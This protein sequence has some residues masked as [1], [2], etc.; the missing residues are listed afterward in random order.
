MW[1]SGET[2]SIV[3][4][5][6][7]FGE[8]ISKKRIVVVQHSLPPWRGPVPGGFLFAVPVVVLGL[9]RLV[10]GLQFRCRPPVESAQT[11]VGV[12]LFNHVCHA[13][14]QPWWRSDTDRD[15]HRARWY[16]R[17]VGQSKLTVPLQCGL[18]GFFGDIHC[19]SSFSPA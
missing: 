15:S 17:L 3:L 8:E 7:I 11:P 14:P 4:L 5:I 12:D 16:P 18:N 6:G 2:G 19:G 10:F 1:E 13:A 9:A